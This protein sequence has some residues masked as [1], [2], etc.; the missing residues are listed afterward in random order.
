MQIQSKSATVH[1]WPIH[2]D[3]RI[4]NH[5]EKP[6]DGTNTVILGYS[7]PKGTGI[8]SST[9]SSLFQTPI[10]ELWGTGRE[11]LDTQH[12]THACVVQH[13]RTAGGVHTLLCSYRRHMQNLPSQ[14]TAAITTTL[15]LGY[16]QAAHHSGPALSGYLARRWNLTGRGPKFFMGDFISINQTSDNKGAVCC[17]LWNW[18][19]SVG[20]EGGWREY[21]KI[22]PTLS[23]QTHHHPV[24]TNAS[25]CFWQTTWCLV[26]FHSQFVDSN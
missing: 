7:V 8:S 16:I 15:Q 18:I 13:H 2:G 12:S 5:Q 26:V 24:C 4:A 25:H 17:C 11:H 9:L 6:S 14:T 1:H 20:G 22:F 19:T 3:M 23:L 10:C 21:G